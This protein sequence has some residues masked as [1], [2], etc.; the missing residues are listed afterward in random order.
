[1]GIVK[2]FSLFTLKSNLFWL[3]FGVA[4]ILRLVLV[5]VLPFGQTV[6]Y[7]LE[8]LNDEPSHYNYVKYLAENRQFPVQ[9]E[10][11][12]S[13]AAFEHNVYEYYQAPFYYVINAFL[14]PITGLRNALYAG[15]MIS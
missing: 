11:S 9:T 7:G 6:K 13:P 3:L 5:W 10:S 2:Q 4:L 15:R 14:V 1:M 12:K 8:G